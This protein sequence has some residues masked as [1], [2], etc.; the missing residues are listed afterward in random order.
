MVIVPHLI[1]FINL[2]S[3][4]YII[5]CVFLFGVIFYHSTIL[6]APAY[7]DPVHYMTKNAQATLDRITKR[8]GYY[9]MSAN[10]PSSCS[11]F[12]LF[13]LSR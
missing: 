4:I 9:D 11:A 13:T 1:P 6:N 10:H 7:A 3:F 12:H 2:K 5:P 8:P